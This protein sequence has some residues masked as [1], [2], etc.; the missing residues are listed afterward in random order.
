MTKKERIQA[1]LRG[2]KPD[3]L[4]Y[5]FWTHMPG[6]DLDPE[7]I[8]QKTYEFYKQ[9]DL[10]LVKTM[11]NGM[12]AIEDFGCTVDYAEIAQ[13]GVAKVVHSPITCAQD[14]GKLSVCPCDR[15]SNARELRH[16]S[17]VL[18]KL[19]GEEVPV[20]FTAFTPITIADKL[21]GGALMSYID[22]GH[23]AVVAQALEIITQTTAQLV[24]AAIHLGADGIFLASQ[25]STYD[26]CTVERYLEFGRPYDLRVLAAAEGGWLNTIHCH[27]DHILFE[28]LKDY[29]VQVFNWHVWETL[30]ALEEAYA[31]TGKCLMGGLDRTDITR[32]D[33]GA[34]QN[35]IFRCF[36]ELGGRHQILTPGCVIRY[37]LDDE[38][39]A[40]IGRTRNEIEVALDRA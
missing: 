10:D 3:K 35:Q 26:K 33:R 5:S 20:L 37:P 16:L 15:G 22:Q 39:L 14:W 30:P 24:R 13:G 17:L 21:C 32:R 8:A 1:V 12:Y 23:G 9:Y 18:E 40:F 25:M 11:N 2:E 27:G 7:A 38:M 34:I 36:K 6:T 31:L 4:P 29:P 19:A 28:V